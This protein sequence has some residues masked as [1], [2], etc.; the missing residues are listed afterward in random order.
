MDS[1]LLEDYCLELQPD[2]VLLCHTNIKYKKHVLGAILPL[3]WSSDFFSFTQTDDEFS[4]FIS[5]RFRGMLS[6]CTSYVH[7]LDTTYKVLKAYQ[8]NHQINELG[9]V[10]KFAQH[11]EQ[12][13]IPILY[14]N[15]FNS[16]IIHAI[17]AEF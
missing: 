13:E 10:A 16:N 5:A 1:T 2:E 8:I 9:I 11:F 7:I 17:L 15:S 4:F 12:L 6:E 14:V 3:M